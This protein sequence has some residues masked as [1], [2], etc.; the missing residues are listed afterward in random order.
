MNEVWN[1]SVIYTGFDD[2]AYEQDMQSLKN[3][4][5]EFAELT[6]NLSQKAPREAL[7]AGLHLQENLTELAEKLASYASLR[8]AANTKDGDAGSQMG[9]IMNILSGMAAP[10]AAFESWASSLPDL[11]ALIAE[12]ELLSQYEFLLSNMQE[13]S[14]HIVRSEER[15]VGKEC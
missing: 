11:K 14:R 10:Q 3:A 2:P 9:R 5:A 13:N 15:R 4:V 7:V 12:D 1:L 8:Q 6:A